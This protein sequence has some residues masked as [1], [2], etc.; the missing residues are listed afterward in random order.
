M[1]CCN[2]D[3]NPRSLCPITGIIDI[4]S[5]KWVICVISVLL[6]VERMRFNKLKN[7]F[8]K[9]HLVLFQ[10]FSA[11]LKIKVLLKGTTILKYHHVWNIPSQKRG[12]LWE[13]LFALF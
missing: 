12:A 10:M 8:T 2:P 9:Y 5:R 4:V 6:E 13:W 7:L 11:Y 1:S 3:N